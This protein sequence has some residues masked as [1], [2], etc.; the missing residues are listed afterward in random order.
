[1]PRFFCNNISNDGAVLSSEDEAHIKKA[2]RMKVGDRLT[3]CDGNGNDYAC[4]LLQVSES[5]SVKVLSISQ[6]KAEPQTAITLYQCLPKGDKLEFILQKAVELGVRR[7]V[8]VLSRY[9]VARPETAAFEKKLDR[10]RKIALEAAKQSGRGRLCE[11][12]SLLTFNQAVEEASASLSRPTSPLNKNSAALI[13]YEGGGE[14]VCKL[15]S[16]EAPAVSLFVGSEGGFCEEEIA[17]AAAAGIKSATL[18]KL[19]LRC[20][21]APIVGITLTLHATE[22]I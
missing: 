3:L 14:R 15:V 11:I 7:F 4:E 16:S 6:N 9:C 19:I 2:L 13:F 1:M 22:Q 18:G 8:P 5:V 12:S 21:T 17:L 10:L 20:E